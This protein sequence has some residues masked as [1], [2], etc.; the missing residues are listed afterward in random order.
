M[1]GGVERVHR[2]DILAVG[3][4]FVR[5]GEIAQLL[6]EH[7]GPRPFAEAGRTFGRREQHGFDL[8]PGRLVSDADLRVEDEAVYPRERAVVQDLGGQDL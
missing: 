5:D 6:E 1:Q 3:V 4:Q 8:P 2:L 7:E